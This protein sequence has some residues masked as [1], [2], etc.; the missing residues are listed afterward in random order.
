MLVKLHWKFQ[1]KSVYLIAKD[2]VPSTTVKPVRVEAAPSAWSSSFIRPAVYRS[3]LGQQQTHI[4]T[5]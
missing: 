2:L 3:L 4:A 1:T 5:A